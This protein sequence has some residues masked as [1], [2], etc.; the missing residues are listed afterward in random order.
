ML[1]PRLLLV[2]A[3]LL[4]LI[5]TASSQ[6]TIRTLKADV[7]DEPFVTARDLIKPN[8]FPNAAYGMKVESVRD[9][10][11]AVVTTTGA[12]FRINKSAGTIECKQR[13]GKAR[14]VATMTLPE[15]VLSG[16]KLSH[17]SSGA[18]IFSSD[19]TS[20]RVNGDSLLMI[21]PAADCQVA[22][23][24]AFTPDYHSQ[25][26]GSFNFFDPHGGISFF[27]HGW[28]P[29]PTFEGVQDPV[30]VT[31][32][33]KGG[34]V[35]WA[36]V[37]PPREYDWAKSFEQRIVMRGSSS[38]RYMFPDELTI[39]WLARAGGFNVFYQHAENVWVN[40]QRDLVPLNEKEYLR[41][42]QQANAE[43]MPVMV[44][45][46]PK[47]F[48]DGTIVED[49]AKNDVDD[50]RA[51]GWTTGS[52]ARIFMFQAKRLKERYETAG[53]YFDE[54]YTNTKAL[55]ANYYLARS[56]RE[57][58][59]DDAPFMYHCTEDALGA[60]VPGDL[61]GTTHCPTLHTY[62]D[63]IYK[64][65]GIGMPGQKLTW[66]NVDEHFPGYTR[67]N[68]GTY[69]VSNAFAIPCLDRGPWIDGPILDDLM[70]RANIR[71]VMPEVFLYSEKSVPY[72][73]DYLPRLRPGLKEELEPTLLKRTGAFEAWR[74]K[75]AGGR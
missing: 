32:N 72:W 10:E 60:R 57:L 35:L 44:Y 48:T 37:S 50:P 56:C 62:F 15:G 8:W 16:L 52:N 40:W 66:E 51:A 41:M 7:S 34:D 30:R 9:G 14:T 20:V 12:E 13:I 4:G 21:Q 25:Y 58:L 6:E 39:R 54:M 47:H 36:G 67:Y 65:E 33:W 28:Q 64:G 26:Q 38:Q 2:L 53:F 22:A 18:A 68:L 63:A 42:M 11:T 43:K 17:E 5:P 23:E 3:L 61:V 49:R 69:N 24:L 73:R 19:R 45:A 1:T 74:K 75:Q 71:L 31:W 27:D 46:S 59:G 29:S 70:K 55:A